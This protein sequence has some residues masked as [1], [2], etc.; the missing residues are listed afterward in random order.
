M[1]QLTF[2]QV[3]KKVCLECGVPQ[4]EAAISAVTG[5]TPGLARIVSWVSQGY[6]ELQNKKLGQWRWM[7]VTAS[8]NTVASTGEYAYT[9]FTDALTSAAITRLHSWR[10]NDI[11]DPPK[12][13]LSSGGI[14]GQSWL[15]YLP[16]DMFKSIY[17]I[18]TQNTATGQPATISVNPQNKIALGNIPNAVYV[19]TLDYHRSAQVLAANDDIPELPVE[20]HYL[21]VYLAMQKYGYYESAQEIISRAKQGILEMRGQLEGNQLP[22]ISKAGPLA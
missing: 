20:F 14:G 11:N 17:R 19:V 2:I 12:I 15:S 6:E 5:N 4:G 16:W 3:C 21:L 22:T 1:S 13:Y 8:A 7:R 9:S 18:G 10:A